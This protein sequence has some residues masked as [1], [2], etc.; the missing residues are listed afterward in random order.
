MTQRLPLTVYMV[1]VPKAIFQWYVYRV[2]DDTFGSV[3]IFRSARQNG[4]DFYGVACFR[5]FGHGP[6]VT[7]WKYF[8]M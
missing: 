5:V 1:I 3:A 6:D 8:R 4:G 2:H 7:W